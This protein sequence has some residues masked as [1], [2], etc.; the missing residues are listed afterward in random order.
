MDVITLVVLARILRRRGAR[1]R[2]AMHGP[3]RL[4]RD[5]LLALPITL[6]LAVAFLAATFLANLAVY[7]GAPPAGPPVSV[8]LW[9]AIWSITVMP[10][11]VALAEETLYRGVALHAL[12][13]RRGP[14]LAVLITAACFGLQHAALSPSSPAEMLARVLATFVLGVLFAVLALRL[15][16]LLPLI[17]AHWAIDVLGLGLPLMILALR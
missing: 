13:D 10:V 4:G 15:R 11:T 1:L 7:G 9:L 6:L 12:T 8:P 3:I 14:V 2:D 16:R 5:L 17:V